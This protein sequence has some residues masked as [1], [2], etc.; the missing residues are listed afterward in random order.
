MERVFE[1]AGIV[2]L[3]RVHKMDDVGSG[4]QIQNLYNDGKTGN[5]ETTLVAEGLS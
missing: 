3:G 2:Q 1:L 4:S 5:D